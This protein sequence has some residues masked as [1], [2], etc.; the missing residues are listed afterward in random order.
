[1][2]AKLTIPTNLLRAVSM[3]CSKDSSRFILQN[4]QVNFRKNRIVLA[5]TDGRLLMAAV[6]E[7][8]WNELCGESF[9]IPASLI[10]YIKNVEEVTIEVDEDY[11][12]LRDVD[13]EGLSVS[14]KTVTGTYPNWK[15][16]VPRGDLKEHSCPVSRAVSD[17]LFSAMSV[18][19][20]KQNQVLE[21]YSVDGD[22]MA[23]HVCHIDDNMFALYMPC[24][25]DDRKMEIP[26][27]LWEE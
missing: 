6:V 1:M 14:R 25:Y 19:K 9:L 24:R 21:G 4:V 26:G 20:H 8:K 17:V 2:K 27:W 22:H 23:P 18:F 7:T 16:V 13:R 3:A 11:V 5:A 10:R 15:G 12:F